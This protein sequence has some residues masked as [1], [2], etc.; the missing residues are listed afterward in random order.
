MRA[1]IERNGGRVFRTEGDAFRA[2]FPIA[3]QALQ[4]ALDA[5]RDL[6]AEPWTE[7]IAP[8]RVRMA[9]HTGVGE[10]RDEDYVG[11]QLNRVARLLAA[12]SGV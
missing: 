10:V 5:Q 2:S 6:L 12:G 9:L 3:L 4:A 8:I 7:D 1:A 11:P